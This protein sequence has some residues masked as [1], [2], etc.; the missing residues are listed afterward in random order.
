MVILFGAQVANFHAGL[1][2][3]GFPLCNGGVLPP[4]APLAALHWAHRVL[5]FAFLG[6]AL[7]MVGRVTRR[8][9]RGRPAAPARRRR[10]VLAATVAQI[11]VAAAMVLHLLPPALRALHLLVGT[12]G[13]GRTG[14]AGVP[15][16]PDAGRGTRDHRGRSRVAGPPSLAAD[17][18][19][20]TK[21]RIISL[22]LV[23]TVAPMFITP[24][25]LPIRR[26]GVLG[27]SWAA[28]S[29]PAAPTRSTCGS[30]GTSTP[31]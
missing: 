9:R 26:P 24:A 7:V 15:L 21:P 31:G 11:G 29:W 16:R 6:L 10:V 4:A 27:A 13:L 23:T 17:L 5:A 1:L 22:L 8:R 28:T 18:V 30:T 12:P 2:C 3:L 19:T 25:G 20:L 14:G